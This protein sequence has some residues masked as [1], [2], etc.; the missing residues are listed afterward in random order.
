[1]KLQIL[2]MHLL[3]VCVGIFIYVYFTG[4][5][6]IEAARNSYWC[7]FGGVFAWFKIKGDSK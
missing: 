6:T 2:L 5:E 7:V 4:Q 3:L 1:M